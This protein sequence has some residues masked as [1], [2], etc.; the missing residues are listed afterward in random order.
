[1]K[2]EMKGNGPEGDIV[3]SLAEQARQG[4]LAVPCDIRHEPAMV[5]DAISRIEACLPSLSPYETL[6]LARADLREVAEQY[7]TH[8]AWS[9]MLEITQKL[10]Q[11]SSL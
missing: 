3:A 4:L 6:E 5:P 9:D 1:M 11:S 10:H 7:E 2:K 8:D